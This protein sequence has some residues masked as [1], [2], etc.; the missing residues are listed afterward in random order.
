MGAQFRLVDG[1][2]A[3]FAGWGQGEIDRL[4]EGSLQRK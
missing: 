4:L 3:F 1:G 2:H